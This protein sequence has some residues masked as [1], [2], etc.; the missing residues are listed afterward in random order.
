[1]PEMRKTWLTVGDWIKR[2]PKNKCSVFFF[3]DIK[4]GM[5]KYSVSINLT[6]DARLQ[7]RKE[8]MGQ[9]KEIKQLL[10]DIEKL[11]YLFLGNF[12]LLCPNCYF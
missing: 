2:G 10:S 7:C 4:K 6:T 8:L 9:G 1:M 5:E 12:Y 3:W 11:W